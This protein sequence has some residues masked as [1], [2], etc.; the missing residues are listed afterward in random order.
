MGLKK[1]FA[2]A[3]ASSLAVVFLNVSNA[4]AQDNNVPIDSLKADS[5]SV[6]SGNDAHPL[7]PLNAVEQQ[8]RRAYRGRN[9]FRPYDAFYAAV[10]GADTALVA[11]NEYAL[12]HMASISKVPAAVAFYFAWERGLAEASS[13][14]ERNAIN[15]KF[16]AVQPY[17]AT[18]LIFS[19][20]KHANN[21]A[22]FLDGLDLP[23][24]A[25]AKA[26]QN[27]RSGRLRVYNNI[28]M[29]MALSEIE[30][31]KET[32]IFNAAGLPPYEYAYRSNRYKYPQR[33]RPEGFDS[34]RAASYQDGGPSNDYNVSTPYEIFKIFEH[35]LQRYP[36]IH[37][38]MSQ[39]LAVDSMSTSSPK[40][41]MNTNTLLE[42]SA[43]ARI[44]NTVGVDGGKTG[45]TRGA[46]KSIAVTAERD[47]VRIIVVRMGGR[48]ST[49]RDQSTQQLVEQSF[50]LLAPYI[51]EQKIQ[52]SLELVRIEQLKADSIALV[53][54]Q[55]SADS[56]AAL[57]VFEDSI[58]ADEPCEPGRGCQCKLTWTASTCW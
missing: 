47:G 53:Y 54:A 41:Y 5:V 10:M 45:T 19:N 44:M 38:F 32:Q 46:G 12:V 2:K 37:E 56:L 50:S 11:K 34:R 31:I 6:V 49:S 18:M 29:P 57:K 42:N 9:P 20:N 3:L 39:P 55:E 58:R 40:R 8:S 7:R 4:K 43:R 16:E 48:S 21:I 51:E 36:K 14:E 15:E 52:D 23:F 17:V 30:D 27:V 24:I 33:L 25:E 22:N 1:S 13:D 35:A 28:V 26:E